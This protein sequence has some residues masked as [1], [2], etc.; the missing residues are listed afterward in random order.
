MI[1]KCFTVC[2]L[3]STAL[4]IPVS[5]QVAETDSLFVQTFHKNTQVVQSE[6]IMKNGVPD[7][8]WKSYY[9]SG[10]IKSEGRWTNSKVDSIW[11]FYNQA[12]E[13]VQSLSY[14][15]GVKSGFSTRYSYDNP[16]NPGQPTMISKAAKAR[17][18][19]HSSKSL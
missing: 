10:V 13:L 2:F 7:G 11:N 9:V 6:G 19:L 16:I 18:L 8:Y 15:L 3:L 12:G 14:K 1:I 4:F 17:S 5:G